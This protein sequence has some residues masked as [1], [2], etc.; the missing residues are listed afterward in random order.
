[1]IKGLSI[2]V[3]FFV[4]SL[5]LSFVIFFLSFIVATQRPSVEKLSADECGFD[6]FDDARTVFDVR[7]YLVAILF[8]VF[9]LEIIYLFPWCT[10]LGVFG[11]FGFWVMMVFLIV[12]TIG[13][14]Y[15]WGKGALEWE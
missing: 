13:F 5:V 14:C 12:L 6:P 11:Y 7:F 10:S 4:V 9:D 3:V 15:E 1:M 8:I 2:L